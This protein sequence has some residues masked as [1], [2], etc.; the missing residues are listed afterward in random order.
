MGY[1]DAD[2]G[3]D[4]ADRRPITRWYI[5]VADILVVLFM[6]TSV[7]VA[8]M[9]GIRELLREMRRLCDSDVIRGR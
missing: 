3:A 2:F 6:V 8:K 4:K 9:I 5:E 1:S 7:G